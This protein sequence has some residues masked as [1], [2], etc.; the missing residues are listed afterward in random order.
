LDFTPLAFHETPGFCRKGPSWK[1]DV[2]LDTNAGK[3]RG[4]INNE[5]LWY[6]MV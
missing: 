3:T 2:K 1:K 4:A 6:E 5:Q